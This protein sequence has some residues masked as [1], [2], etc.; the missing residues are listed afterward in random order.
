VKKEK[1]PIKQQGHVPELATPPSRAFARTLGVLRWYFDPEFLHLERAS[2]RRPTLFVANHS[3]WNVFD[4]MLFADAL[5]R[6][7]GI[8][9][10]PLSD[11]GH[12]KVP[13]WRDLL[14]Q[15]G[16][17]L[18]SR[19]NCAAL[20]RAGHNV[21]VFP[22]G[23][24]EVFKRK[25]ESYRLLWKERYGFVRLAIEHGYTITPYATVGAEESLDVL[26]DAGDYMKSPIGK[27]LASSGIAERHLRSGEELPPLVRGL[28]LTP[29][30]RPEKM[31]FVVGKPIDTRRF[32][33]RH[34]DAETLARVRER[35]GRQLEQLIE[36]GRAHRAR[37]AKGGLVRRTLNRL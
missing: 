35:V 16:S 2:R 33:G 9:L 4:A 8:V 37:G 1:T 6:E 5:Y 29:L 14:V 31:Y 12:F 15:Q 13:L 34:D 26:L 23:A 3:V 10:R 21:L 11:R 18:G 20:M 7:R 25:G 17:V 30:P 36:E 32:R 27:L 19:E 28:G 24:R 22:G